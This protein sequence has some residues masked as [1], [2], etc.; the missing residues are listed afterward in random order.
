[1][2][3]NRTDGGSRRFILVEMEEA[4]CQSVTAERLT[5]AIQGHN[6]LPA[7]GGGFRYC[8]LGPPVFDETGG[9]RTGVKFGELAAH[10]Y[11]TET[12]EPI[13]KRNNGRTPLLGVHNG[14]AVYLLFNGI[15]GDRS[16]GGGNVLTNAVLKA[17]P[18]HDG[19]RV[20]YG[21]GCRLRKPRLKREG[22]VFKQIPYGIKVS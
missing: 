1:L 3:V 16:P 10:V 21:E 14:K 18:L 9:I 8:R 13:P 2:D 4:I 11:F 19:P 15:L 7:L 5:R 22:I 20:I 12:G 17:L 6:D